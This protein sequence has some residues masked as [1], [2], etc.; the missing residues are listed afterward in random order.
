MNERLKKIRLE[1]G[2]SQEEFGKKI[3]IESRAHISALEKGNRNITDRI[4]NDVCREFDINEDWL[5]TG[6]GNMK[7]EIPNK[8]AFYLGQIEG[9]D[10]EFIRDLIEIYMEL[11]PDSKKALRVL[12]EKMVEKRKNRGQN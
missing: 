3:G 12:A 9:G 7:K 2:M 8:L 10:D 11:D 4:V 5:R 1:N 6:I